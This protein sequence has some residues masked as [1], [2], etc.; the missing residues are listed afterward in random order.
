[1]RMFLLENKCSFSLVL[2]S[3]LN[4]K[5]TQKKKIQKNVRLFLPCFTNLY[6][7]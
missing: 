4:D 5:D 6:D 1:M 3:L 7:S 2:L